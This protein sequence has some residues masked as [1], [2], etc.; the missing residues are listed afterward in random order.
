LSPA[1]EGHQRRRLKLGCRGA[2][3]FGDLGV[4]R[5][6][7]DDDEL[8]SRVLVEY[9]HRRERRAAT[10]CGGQV[11]PTHSQHGSDADIVRVEQTGDFLGAGARRGHDADRTRAQ[12]VGEAQAET[13]HDSSSA[14]RAHDERVVA[15][16]LVLQHDL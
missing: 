8:R 9:L 10:H 3:L 5:F 15:S 12:C 11:A 2:H 7:Q 13:T 4:G 16:R 14:I 6:R 1:D